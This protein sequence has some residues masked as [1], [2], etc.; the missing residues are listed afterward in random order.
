MRTEH[1]R[2]KAS[3]LKMKRSRT[4]RNLEI[5][6]LK[7]HTIIYELTH[8]VIYHRTKYG[9]NKAMADAVSLADMLGI[10]GMNKGVYSH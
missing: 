1:L 9:A 8:S 6:N 10:A 3:R 4:R 2:R 7:G 5:E